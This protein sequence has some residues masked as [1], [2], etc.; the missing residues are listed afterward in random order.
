MKKQLKNCLVYTIDGAKNIQYLAMVQDKDL[1]RLVHVDADPNSDKVFAMYWQLKYT[2]VI[3]EVINDK[4]FKDTIGIK[5]KS[6]TRIIKDYNAEAQGVYDGISAITYKDVFDMMWDELHIYVSRKSL[7]LIKSVSDE[8]NKLPYAEKSFNKN[9]RLVKFGNTIGLIV[10]SIALFIDERGNIFR[11]IVDTI[12]TEC[13]NEFNT[14]LK[15]IE[16]PM[17][18]TQDNWKTLPTR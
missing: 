9:S 18:I 2:S 15:S 5:D 4:S 7:K 11:D 13:I 16:Y 1:F 6:V 8:L 17:Q 12:N 3:L 10:R 14:F